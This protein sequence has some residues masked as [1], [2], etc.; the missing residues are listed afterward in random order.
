MTVIEHGS[1]V[2][3]AY[4]LTDASGDV[5]DGS[6]EGQP[7][8]YVH[9]EQ[10]ILPALEAALAG[11]RVGDEADLTLP[12]EDAYGVIDPQALTEVPKRSLPPEALFPGTELTAKKSTGEKMF[13]TVKEV[14]D[15]TVVINMNHPFAGK[16]LHFHLRVLQIVPPPR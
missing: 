3:L 8:T 6:A 9:G 7:F 16:T 13:V 14:R 4:T 12:P 10:Q 15:E 1:L 5:L 2:E 11:K